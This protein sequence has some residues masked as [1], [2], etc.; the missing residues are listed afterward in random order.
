MTDLAEDSKGEIYDKETYKNILTYGATHPDS[1]FEGQILKQW[2]DTALLASVFPGEQLRAAKAAAEE[3]GAEIVQGDRPQVVTFTR[4]AREW[5]SFIGFFHSWYQTLFGISLK[6][7]L[8]KTF[9]AWPAM[10][11][12]I[13]NQRDKFMAATLQEMAKEHDT[14]VAVVDAKHVNGIKNYIHDEIDK[15]DL[16]KLPNYPEIQAY[17]Y[18]WA[19]VICWVSTAAWLIS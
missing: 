3:V 7:E 8:K 16:V 5:W 4:Q 10:V 9:R 11:D 18:I 15:A 12:I 17:M 1:V 13:L 2:R 6:Q 19:F 14:I